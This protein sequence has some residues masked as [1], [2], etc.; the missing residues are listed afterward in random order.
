[1]EGS[2]MI[3]RLIACVRGIAERRRIG[4]DVDEEL[5]FHI[6]QEIET[7]VSRG[8]SPIEA[9]RM[10]L[11]DLGGL[12]QVTQ[13]LRDVRTS[14]LDLLSCDVRHTLRS[15]RRSP[16]FFAT[17]VVTLALGIGGS[18]ALFSIVHF[19]S[20]SLG[21]RYGSYSTQRGLGSVSVSYRKATLMRDRG[22]GSLAV[23]CC[24]SWR[25]LFTS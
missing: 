10:A 13:A 22:F 6:D 3:A 21:L 5:R 8:V 24:G 19:F 2:G 14:W 11:R 9:R 12:T 1:M 4:A 18:T 7:H 20:S 16:L 25:F 15:L 23:C 17:A